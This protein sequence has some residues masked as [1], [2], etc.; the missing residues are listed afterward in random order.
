[1]LRGIGFDIGAIEWICP[2]LMRP[3]FSHRSNPP[4]QGP[5]AAIP[6]VEIRNGAEIRRIERYNAH[7]IDVLAGRLGDPVRCEEEMQRQ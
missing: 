4:E 2:S 5:A 3:A 1:V 6:F 7:K